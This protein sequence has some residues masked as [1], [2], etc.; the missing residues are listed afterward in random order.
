MSNKVSVLCNVCEK[1]HVLLY[2][3]QI[4]WQSDDQIICTTCYDKKQED[5]YANKVDI[6]LK[7]VLYGVDKSLSD[8]NELKDMLYES[9]LESIGDAG[10]FKKYEIKLLDYDKTQLKHDEDY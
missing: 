2:K 4:A 7:L 8:I 5:A 1:N 6:G 3:S 10:I 9:S